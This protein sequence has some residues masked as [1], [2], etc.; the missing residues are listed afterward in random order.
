M[1]L[2][3]QH[4]ATLDEL[5]RHLDASGIAFDRSHISV[6]FRSLAG[7]IKRG[8]LDPLSP[9]LGMLIYRAV[10]KATELLPCFTSRELANTLWA[11]ARMGHNPGETFMSAFLYRAEEELP[12]FNSQDLANTLWALARM[13][14]NPGEMFMSAFLDRAETELPSFNSQS[15]TNILWA[16]ERWVTIQSRD[17]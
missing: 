17:A 4:S 16:L 7:V 12:S 9:R 2:Q 1:A 11:L 6:F 13:G 14:H 8:N 15:L 5:E 3:I 10:N